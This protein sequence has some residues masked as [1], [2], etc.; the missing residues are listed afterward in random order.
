MSVA[1]FAIENG[2][3]T[4]IDSNDND[5]VISVL[6][7]EGE[8][9]VIDYNSAILNTAI[10]NT[11]E[12]IGSDGAIPIPN[13]TGPVFQK[14]MEWCDHYAYQRVDGK[15]GDDFEHDENFDKQFLEECLK[16]DNPKKTI[17]DDYLLELLQAANY[18][19]NQHLLNICA[20]RVVECIKGKTIEE[21]RKEN[22]ISTTYRVSEKG[23]TPT[24][25]PDGL[26]KIGYTQEEEEE[27][28]KIKPYEEWVKEL[29]QEKKAKEENK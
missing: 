7:A 15:T 19:E 18:L 11:M 9:H 5:S 20:R 17:N 27:L 25:G 8:E 4:N 21:I 3:L 1:K 13:I 24:T 28:M 6:T 16:T 29:E 10:K 14:V 12:D 2:T 22:G 26:V 23:E